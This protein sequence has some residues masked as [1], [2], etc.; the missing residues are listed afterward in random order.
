MNRDGLRK[1]RGCPHCCRQVVS[2][3]PASQHLMVSL[4]VRL[5]SGEHD[6]QNFGVEAMP[7]DPIQHAILV[8]YIKPFYTMRPR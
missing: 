1:A 4:P 8:L 3:A 6:L 2:A 5:Q 7:S